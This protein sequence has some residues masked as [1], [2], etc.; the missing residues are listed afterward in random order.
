MEK[1]IEAYDIKNFRNFI[2]RVNLSCPIKIQKT[3]KYGIWQNSVI[4]VSKYCF[5]YFIKVTYVKYYSL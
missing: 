3:W 1:Y 4:F 5:F 2:S